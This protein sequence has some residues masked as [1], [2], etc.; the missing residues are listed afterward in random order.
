MVG[1]KATWL[2]NKKILWWNWEKL[3]EKNFDPTP[4]LF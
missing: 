2:G 1:L 4:Y 3:K